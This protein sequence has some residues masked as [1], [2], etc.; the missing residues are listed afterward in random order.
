M[1]P[2]TAW[3]PRS[4]GTGAG[5]PSA[6]LGPGPWGQGWT[7][8]PPDERALSEGRA[9]KGSHLDDE[10]VLKH[11]IPH[12][13]Q[14][15][16]LH[17]RPDVGHGQGPPRGRADLADGAAHRLLRPSQGVRAGALGLWHPGGRGESTRGW[18]RCAS[19]LGAPRG[20]PRSPPL[21]PHHLDRGVRPRLRA[22]S[23]AGRTSLGS[24]LVPRRPNGPHGS[25]WLLTASSGCRAAD[26]GRRESQDHP[27]G[28]MEWP[29]SMT[30][31]RQRFH[32]D[33]VCFRKLLA[34]I[35]ADVFRFFLK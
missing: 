4:V 15:L 16:V 10:R 9:R 25:L 31:G 26:P 3:G 14:P 22:P 34:A 29:V 33:L 18:T 30:T 7:R 8:A 27:L 12:D 19:Q 5:A 6:A 13:P 1:P 20:A 11:G 21:G 23:G 17:A 2:V 24:L 35:K 28:K 32:V